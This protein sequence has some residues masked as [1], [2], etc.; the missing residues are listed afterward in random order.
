MKPLFCSKACIYTTEYEFM[1]L[2]FHINDGETLTADFLPL[3]PTNF[4]STPL[5][6][7]TGILS[8]SLYGIIETAEDL[9]L[10][11]KRRT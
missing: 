5:G 2:V 6:G 7:G 9:R 3:I 4:V 1:T 11:W 10:A 8:D